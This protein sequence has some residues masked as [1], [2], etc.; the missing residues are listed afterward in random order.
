MTMLGQG[1]TGEQ[2]HPGPRIWKRKLIL[3][4]LLMRMYFAKSNINFSVPAVDFYYFHIE[5]YKFLGFNLLSI[6]E[7]TIP[8]S[9]LRFQ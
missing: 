3:A 6:K 9:T 5:M 8:F 1:D 7:R 4:T 2:M